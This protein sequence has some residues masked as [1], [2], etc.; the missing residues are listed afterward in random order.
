MAKELTHRGFEL[1]ELGWSKS[2]VSRYIDLWDYRQRWGAINLERED[3]L[4]LRKAE[5]ALPTIKPGKA[6]VTK[7]ITEKSYFK[8]IVYFLDVMNSFENSISIPDGSRG[9]WPVLLEEEIR[10]LE[11]Y[12]PVLGLPDAIKAKAFMPFREGI[13]E[14]SMK[15]FKEQIQVFDFDFSSLLSSTD[16]K[17]DKNWKALRDTSFQDDNLYPV[18]KKENIFEYRKE[19]RGKTVSI[20]KDTLPSL[21]ETDK[22]EPSD[23]WIPESNS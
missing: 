17:C 12:Q 18:M 20:V 14:I 2:D 7:P 4:F 11:Y 21:S 19:V 1:K 13:V 10:A 9:L 15:K 3:R 5:I 16:E 23:D 22:P 6:S 8:R